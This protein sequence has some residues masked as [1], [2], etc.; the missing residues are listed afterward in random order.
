MNQMNNFPNNLQ[1]FN[2]MFNMMPMVI[3][4]K[5]K[6]KEKIILNFFKIILYFINSF[7]TKLFIFMK[8]QFSYKIFKLFKDIL[9]I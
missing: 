5:N 6:I 8:K 2:P 3:K 4:K 9:Y 7:K 1:S